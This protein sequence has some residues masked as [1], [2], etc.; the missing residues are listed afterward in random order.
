MNI[1]LSKRE[2]R[3]LL[4]L[5]YTGNWVLNSQ[6]ENDRIGEYDQLQS[7]I[8]AH[9]RQLN[10][11]ELIDD[12]MGDNIPSQMYTGGGIH[13]AIMDYEDT[14]FFNILAEELARRDLDGL[15]LDG[16]DKGELDERTERYAEEFE[17]NGI[18]NVVVHGVDDEE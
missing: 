4:D 1:E 13:E 9:C 10:M 14:V 5:V 7:K 17:H 3:L 6:R 12:C 11:N 16:A 8:F 18:E 2:F 15:D